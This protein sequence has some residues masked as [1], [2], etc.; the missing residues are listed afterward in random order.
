MPPRKTKLAK[1]LKL[2]RLEADL[3]QVEVGDRLG[4]SATTVHNWE[5]GKY[6]PSASQVQAIDDL[7]VA[8]TEQDVDVSDL[9]SDCAA[10]E[11]DDV[12]ESLSGLPETPLVQ[13]VISVVTNDLELLFV[14]LSNARPGGIGNVAARDELGWRQRGRFERARDTLVAAGVVKVKRGGRGGH[15][16]TVDGEDLPDFDS[17]DV[18]TERGLYERLVGPLV[19]VL[20]A[21]EEGPA[22][23]VGLS[24]VA[25]AVTGDLGSMDTGGRMSRPDLVGAVRRPMPLT[26]FHALEIHG[27]EVKPYWAAERIGVYEAVAQQALGLCTHAWAVLYLPSH[28]VSLRKRHRKVVEDVRSKLDAVQREASSLGVGLIVVDHLG[29]GGQH[30]RAYPKRY[31]ADPHRLDKFLHKACPSLLNSIDFDPNAAVL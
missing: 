14:V 29:D 31:G 19:R 3:T 18:A 7:L 8:P 23:D 15:L 10:L 11:M 1:H 2:V 24:D 12:T 27:F 21:G 5:I 22:D 17:L 30:V 16:V 6:R 26:K 28:D 9:E 13:D 20:C 4:V 25:V